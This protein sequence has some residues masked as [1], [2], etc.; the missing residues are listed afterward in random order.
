LTKSAIKI[1]YNENQIL[2]DSFEKALPFSIGTDLYSRNGILGT[3]DI[4]FSHSNKICLDDKEVRF[5]STLNVNQLM[6]LFYHLKSQSIFLTH[7]LKTLGLASATNNEKCTLVKNRLLLIHLCLIGINKTNFSPEDKLQF[8]TLL[9]YQYLRQ[10][11]ITSGNKIE[12]QFGFNNP[13]PESLFESIPLDTLIRNKCYS[14]IGKQMQCASQDEEICY[15]SKLEGSRLFNLS[16]KDIEINYLDFKRNIQSVTNA[17]LDSLSKALS[18]TNQ[19]LRLLEVQMEKLNRDMGNQDNSWAVISLMNKFSSLEYEIAYQLF[20]EKIKTT[21]SKNPSNIEA[22]YSY[23]SLLLN[24]N[25][26]DE[27]MRL[28]ESFGNYILNKRVLN[29]KIQIELNMLMERKGVRAVLDTLLG[30]NFDKDV[31]NKFLLNSVGAY[32]KKNTKKN[33]EALRH[34]SVNYASLIDSINLTVFTSLIKDEFKF[35]NGHE[36]FDFGNL[37]A[38]NIFKVNDAYFVIN[39]F[40]KYGYKGEADY[41]EYNLWRKYCGGLY[42]FKQ[43]DY[44]VKINPTLAAFG[45]A[46]YFNQNQCNHLSALKLDSLEFPLEKYKNYVS[47]KL[48]PLF[49]TSTKCYDEIDKLKA[50]GDAYYF[51]GEKQKCDYYYGIAKSKEAIE[52]K[53]EAVSQ[54]SYNTVYGGGG[55]IIKTGKRGGRYYINSNGNK[56]YVGKGRR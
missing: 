26:F 38:K 29:L 30:K 44:L 23:C 51:I 19:D 36:L 5:I 31:I 13:N 42:A 32:C 45:R 52:R 34:L 21:L 37:S 9:K 15:K 53:K 43:D 47:N 55:R 25:R 22:I 56:T 35:Y 24:S 46:V 27:A 18:L 48:I 4:L 10:S 17:K 39:L 50:L 1:Q 6:N 20:N 11:S 16:E 8:Y 28:S 2:A 33:I 54:N 7:K 3:D 41:V 12:N 40:R 14:I 49:K